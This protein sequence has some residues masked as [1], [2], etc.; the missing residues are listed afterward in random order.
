MTDYG[1]GD[2]AYFL[3]DQIADDKADSRHGLRAWTWADG[4]QV[5]GRWARECEAKWRIVAFHRPSTDHPHGWNAYCV[6]CY[7]EGGMD[8]APNYPCKTIRL[9]AAVYSDHPDYRE[10]W[11]P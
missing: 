5:P 6:G 11:K 2:I 4:K 9:L 3:R 1:R 10:D 8:G 7:E